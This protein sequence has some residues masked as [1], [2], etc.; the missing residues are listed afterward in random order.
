MDLRKQTSL[1]ILDEHVLN[2]DVFS[3]LI[4]LPEIKR[5]LAFGRHKDDEL[6]LREL[7]DKPELVLRSRRMRPGPTR[8]KRALSLEHAA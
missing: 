1:E 8:R 6:G 3:A 4:E 2:D 7:F 5:E